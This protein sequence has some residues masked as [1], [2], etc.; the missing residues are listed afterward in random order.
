MISENIC[1]RL[2]AYYSFNAIE[3]DFAE[4]LVESLMTVI[5]QIY[6]QTSEDK[7]ID[8]GIKLIKEYL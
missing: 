7:L 5:Y 8:I 4:E 6:E 2:A 1:N 3:E